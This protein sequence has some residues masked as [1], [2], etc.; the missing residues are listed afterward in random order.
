MA[1]EVRLDQ[2]KDELLQDT[3]SAP[4]S[5]APQAHLAQ[6]TANPEAIPN[7]QFQKPNQDSYSGFPNKK[8]SQEQFSS[9]HGQVCGRYRGKGGRGSVQCQVRGKFG[10]DAS[11]CFHR[12]DPNY[13]AYSSQQ[14]F[15]G[16]QHAQPQFQTQ[17]PN[18]SQFQQPQWHS[19]PPQQQFTGYHVPNQWQT[20]Q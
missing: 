10:H 6:K 19:V 17:Q 1:R 5:T 15:T 20:R 4:D 11:I 13:Q 18:F 8:F 12:F 7:S 2:Y 9:F 3:S 14:P 16:Y